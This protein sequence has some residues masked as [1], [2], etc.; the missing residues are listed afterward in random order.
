MWFSKWL[1]ILAACCLVVLGLGAEG[2]RAESVPVRVG[3]SRTSFVL[4]TRTGYGLASDGRFAVFAPAPSGTFLPDPVPTEYVIDDQTGVR[5]T[6]ELPRGCASANI[7]GFDPTLT[8]LV[9][10]PEFLYYCNT[11]TTDPIPITLYDL[12]HRRGVKVPCGASCQGIE[13]ESG[14]VIGLGTRWLEYETYA[15]PHCG[16]SPQ[17]EYYNIRAG[18]LTP[19]PSLGSHRVIDLNSPTLK[20]SICLPQPPPAD[21]SI[22]P[23]GRV[24][25]VNTYGP[26]GA[27]VVEGCDPRVMRSIPQP[28]QAGALQGSATAVVWQPIQSDGAWNGEFDGLTL[29]DL[30]PFSLTV[31]AQLRPCR[32]VD[33][34][35][36]VCGPHQFALTSG[37]LYL[38]AG[39]QSIWAMPLP[40]SHTPPQTWV[41]SPITPPR[42][43]SRHLR[44]TRKVVLGSATYPMGSA[45]F[46]P[47]NRGGFG[48]PHPPVF[49]NRV[50]F[51]SEVTHIHWRHWGQTIATGWGRTRIPFSTSG[52]PSGYAKHPDPVKLIVYD[53]GRCTPH[54]PLAYRRLDVREPNQPGG[55]LGPWQSWSGFQ[56][57]C[58]SPVSP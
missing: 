58:H 14:Q 43:P 7:L 6:L 41:A 46:A 24:N 53:L 42:G 19:A 12:V 37:R 5:S 15:P 23:L 20:R 16:C 22:T 36:S 18:E 4:V 56:T 48:R 55:A 11:G 57:L 38:Q 51:Y 39:G 47:V 2:A 33:G 1:S 28:S 30:R 44:R 3:Q 13:Q 31:P 49:S 52:G 34:D 27:A 32:P 45:N 26:R 25:L 10:A 8:L 29:P 40:G 17:P 35:P 50:D 9:S 21:A 54:G